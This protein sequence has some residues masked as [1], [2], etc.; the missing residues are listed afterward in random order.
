L[1]ADGGPDALRT[2]PEFMLRRHLNDLLA[3]RKGRRTENFPPGSGRV[4]IFTRLPPRADFTCGYEAP[5]FAHPVDGWG[6]H[7]G[8]DFGIMVR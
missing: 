6:F 2:V 4:R 5:D 3:V 1:P 8:A 7:R